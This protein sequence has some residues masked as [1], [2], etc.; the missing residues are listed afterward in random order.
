MSAARAD[1]CL[2]GIDLGSTSL[3]AV[4][5]DLSGAVLASGSRPT[6]R[7]HPDPSHPD[8]T[9]WDPAQIWGGTADSIQEAVSKLKDPA[10]IAAVAV[11]GM[12]M[13]GVPVDEKGQWLYPF[14]SWLCPRTEPQRQWWE[15]TITAEKTFS[16]GGNTLWRYSTALRL[17]WMA[18]H[19]PK[20]LSRTRK[21]L[22]IEDFLNFMLCRKEATDYS[23]ASCTLLFDQK[24]RRWSEE[25][26]GLSGI[27][28]RL[29]CDPKPSGTLLGEVSAAAA[30][31]TGLREGTPV[32]LGGHDYL[33]GALPVGAF[34]PGV[35]LDVSGTW[36]VVQATIPR[37]VLTPELQRIGAT[38]ECHAA[39]GMYS[40]MGAAV[41]ADML[42]WYRKEYGFEAKAKA[43]ARG[44]ADWDT[45]MEE[46]SSSRPGSGGVLFLPHA[47]GSGCP[48]VDTRS[49]GSF[50]GI[51][52][53]TTRGDLLRALIEGLDFQLLDIVREMQSGV[54]F[55]AEKLVVV[56]GAA[57]NAFWMQ[58]KADVTGMRIEVPEVEDATPLGAAMLA[59][60]GVGIYRDEKD[61]FERVRKDGA[62]YEPDRR[63]TER[64]S[65]WFSIYKLLYPALASVNHAITNKLQQDSPA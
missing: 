2:L 33:C 18:E 47:S 6:E 8:W 64:Y 57:R 41:S 51:G 50:V 49:R 65:D 10:S 12:G 32:V 20:I 29:L 4:A 55:A 44:C 15:K 5:Y 14:I 60:I 16:I 19:E 54:G 11:T 17:L 9:V 58:N 39:T 25:I 3:K 30:K 53:A 13:D 61:A 1:S 38:V 24:K 52:S 40:V 42:E 21:W 45:L 7:F 28:K 36:E 35:L 43:A 37:P 26:L 34:I 23:M 63:K 27:D 59:G 46:A 62:S 56:G 48:V 22:L 31:A